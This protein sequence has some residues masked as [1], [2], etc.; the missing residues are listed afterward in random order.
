MDNEVN[1]SLLVLVPLSKTTPVTDSSDQHLAASEGSH[2]TM[3]G[4]GVGFYLSSTEAILFTYVKD[5]ICSTVNLQRPAE[6]HLAALQTPN[7]P[8]LGLDP[9]V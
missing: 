3:W 7:S 9:I 1:L 2:H 5:T 6:P 8:G 4:R